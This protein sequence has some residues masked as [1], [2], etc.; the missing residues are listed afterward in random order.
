MENKQQIIITDK[1]KVEIDAVTAVRSFD[2]D[3]VLLDTA[4]TQI[5]IEGSDLKIENFEKSSTKILIT[6]NICGVYYLNKRDKKRGRG[7]IR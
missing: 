5:S 2:E 6:G 4:T 3:G 1:N 7:V